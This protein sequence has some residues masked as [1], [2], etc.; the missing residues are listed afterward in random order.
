MPFEFGATI[1]YFTDVFL[2]APIIHTIAKNPIYTALLITFI[3]MIIIIFIFR[4]AETEETLLTMSM[5]AGF[6]IFLMMLGILMVHNR[7]LIDENK[8]ESKSAAYDGVFS[9][10]YDNQGL[11]GAPIP[12]SMEGSIVSVGSILKTRQRGED[13]EKNM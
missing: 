4:D 11:T 10:A 13:S 9:G 8:A 5:R 12:A 3:I 7:V 1:N 6:W 2:R